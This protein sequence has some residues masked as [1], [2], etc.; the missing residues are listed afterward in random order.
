MLV[1]VSAT[2]VILEEFFSPSLPDDRY[3]KLGS[4]SDQRAEVSGNIVWYDALA[5][6]PEVLR[7]FSSF[8]SN[9][10]LWVLFLLRRHN[11]RQDKFIDSFEKLKRTIW[12]SFQNFVIFSIHGVILSLCCR[13]RLQNDSG[14]YKYPVRQ[15]PRFFSS[16]CS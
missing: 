14:V 4:K 15:I 3:L 5:P 11:F 1:A 2:H 12:A 13:T 6:R 7:S 16:L 8:Y 9:N 10:V